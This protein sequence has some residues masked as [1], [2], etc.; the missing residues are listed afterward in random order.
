MWLF[1]VTGLEAVRLGKPRTR[2]S[3][4]FKSLENAA[5]FCD[6]TCLDFGGSWA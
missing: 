1:K 4:V 6:L 2:F 3:K 5:K